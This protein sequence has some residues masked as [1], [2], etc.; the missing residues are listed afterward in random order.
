[1]KFFILIQVVMTFELGNSTFRNDFQPKWYLWRRL[2]WKKR[3]PLLYNSSHQCPNCFRYWTFVRYHSRLLI[4]ANMCL[5]DF[6][7]I[8]LR[9]SH[10][11]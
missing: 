2:N 6:A 7:Q 4:T 5:D 11:L 10:S 8:L 9:Q 3:Y 1:M